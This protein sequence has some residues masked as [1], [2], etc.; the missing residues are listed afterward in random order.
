MAQKDSRPIEQP[1]ERPSEQDVELQQR[2][3]ARHANRSELPLTDAEANLQ[4]RYAM[5]SLNGGDAEK[6]DQIREEAKRLSLSIAD[7]V[8]ESDEREHALHYLDLS[9]LCAH[10]A[11]SR[12]AQ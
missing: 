7:L 8:P 9:V 1:D 3:E 6:H 10:A 4:R 5:Q 12:D 2:I 11:I